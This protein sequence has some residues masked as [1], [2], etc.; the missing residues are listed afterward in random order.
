MNQRRSLHAAS[1][2]A[3]G[4]RPP[5][6]P[7]TR[8]WV[9]SSSATARCCREARTCRGG[10]PPRRSACA[11][12]C[13]RHRGDPLREP[14]TLC[15]QGRTPPCA[16]VVAAAGL[17]TRR[18]GD[19]RPRPSRRRG[20]D[21]LPARARCRGD[22][23]RLCR[24]TRSVLNAPYLHHRTTGRPC[25]TLKL[26]LSLDGKLAAADG[27]SR[28]ITG[29]GA[30]R[31]VHRR[32]GSSAMRCLV[33]A[34]TVVAD[35]PSLTV[36][37]VDAPRQPVR[38]VCRC[39]G[40]DPG[41]ERVFERGEV[42]RDDDDRVLPTRS[43]PRGRKPAQRWSSLAQDATGRGGSGRRARQPW[44]PRMARDLLR[45]WCR[46]WRRRCSPEDL[47]DRL[48][49]YYGPST[50]RRFGCRPG[51]SWG[52]PTIERGSYGGRP[53]PSRRVGDDVLVVVTE[54][55]PL[56]FTGIDH[57]SGKRAEGVDAARACSS[58]DRGTRASRGS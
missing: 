45:G 56:M 13:G 29:D 51:R 25:V 28:W 12:G 24:R 31:R 40:S 11:T 55:G 34:G 39:P 5:S 1:P 23:R 8:V 58:S 49:L 43:R 21:R 57:A 50:R 47:V 2:R 14:R 38:V 3:C 46:S 52:R 6:R 36:R 32:V 44:R 41:I 48:E 20:G 33:G 4:T 9:R 7:R 37:D 35:D 19:R 27:S 42:D 22:G 26:A 54:E 15:P 30:R 17:D 10:E 16:P 18:G 53:E